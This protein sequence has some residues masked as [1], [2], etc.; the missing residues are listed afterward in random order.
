MVHPHLDVVKRSSQSG[1]SVGELTPSG[2]ER[3]PSLNP[4]LLLG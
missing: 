1:V 3:N 2:T 4:A